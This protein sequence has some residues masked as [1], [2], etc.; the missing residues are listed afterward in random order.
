MKQR[1]VFLVTLT[2]LIGVMFGCGIFSERY[3]KTETENHT[4]SAAGKSSLNLDNVNGRIEI[5][6][7]D[8]SS[9]IRIIARKEVTVPKKDLDKPFEEI[10]LT[11]DTSGS[12]IR[13]DSEYKTKTKVKFFNFGSNR[14]PRV[15]YEIFVPA[16]FQLVL[17]NVNGDITSGRLS[18]DMNIELVNGDVNIDNFTGLFESE[19]TNGE[20]SLEIDSTSG[21]DIETVNGSVDLSLGSSV[22][23]NLKVET[24]NGK[25]IE[26]NLPLNN[27]KR[28]KKYLK[29]DL[30]EGQ[31]SSISI[32]TVN[33]RITLKGKGKNW[34]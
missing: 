28:E 34:Q 29:A 30:G 14:S 12:E 11:I 20:I 16:N 4:I 2:V 19:I 10:K 21:I 17:S 22:S 23:G 18:A 33:G 25:I 7:S 31:K 32:S 8:D 27:V 5:N 15:D 24:T 1:I 9:T 26:E 6:Q 3:E 13:I